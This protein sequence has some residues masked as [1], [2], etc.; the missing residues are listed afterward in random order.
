[1]HP[2]TDVACMIW[3]SQAADLEQIPG[4]RLPAAS[5]AWS[6]LQV[7]RK[8]PDTYFL[9]LGTEHPSER[10]TMRL[11]RDL[12]H[13]VAPFLLLHPCFRCNKHA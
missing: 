13:Q 7:L 4:R 1:M 11:T 5:R 12:I 3:L 9:Q 8:H 10:L 6:A 2:T